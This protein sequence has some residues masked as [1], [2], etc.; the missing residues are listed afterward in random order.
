MDSGACGRD[1]RRALPDPKCEAI[2]RSEFRISGMEP[3]SAQQVFV[4][5]QSVEEDVNAPRRFHCSH[6]IRISKGVS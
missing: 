5:E 1:K 6:S 3:L 2:E 4:H